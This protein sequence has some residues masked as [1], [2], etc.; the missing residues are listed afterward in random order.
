M[1]DCTVGADTVQRRH[2]NSVRPPTTPK[3]QQQKREKQ[4]TTKKST[5]AKW[6]TLIDG[7][8]KIVGDLSKDKEGEKHQKSIVKLT[9]QVHTLWTQ[10]SQKKNPAQKQLSRIEKKLNNLTVGGGSMNQTKLNICGG[11]SSLNQT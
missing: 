2:E 4:Q 9:Q 6:H 8:N 5:D 11:Q 1:T 3:P 7:L 10:V